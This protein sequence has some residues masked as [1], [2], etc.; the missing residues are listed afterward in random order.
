[1]ALQF[2]TATWNDPKPDHELVIKF[3]EERD[4]W[5]WVFQ[6]EQGEKTARKHYQMRLNLLKAGRCVKATLLDTFKAGGFD[7][8]NLT[9]LPE[10]NNGIAKDSSLFYCTKVESRLRGPWADATFTPPTKKRKY[11]G[12][13]LQMMNTPF[14][15]QKHIMELIDSPTDDRKINWVC[16]ESGNVGKTK[17]QKW[18][19]WKGMAKRIPMGLAHQIK[20]ALATTQPDVKAFVMNIPRVSGKEEAQ[21]E[22][23][24]AIEEIKDGWV[25]AVMFGKEVE[26]Y[27]EPPHI[28]IFS[29]EKPNRMLASADRWRIWSLESPLQERLQDLD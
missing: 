25:G 10:S 9:L 13:D 22:L 12:A 24:S 23:F 27:A 18:L 26:W 3:L 29:N 2:W 7:T 20:N 21:K 4:D 19:C 14:G 6:E 16:N 11:E 17:L 8:K 1:M 5:K 15:W 28:W